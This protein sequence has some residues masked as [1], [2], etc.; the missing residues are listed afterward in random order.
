MK[1][2]KK[3]FLIIS[4][5]ILAGLFLGVVVVHAIFYVPNSE[6]SV[7]VPLAS[8][9]ES[10]QEHLN[11]STPQ[12][13]INKN[14]TA[15][16]YPVS[17]PKQLRIPSIKVDAK[18]QYV[19]ITKNGKMATPN[20]FTDVGWFQYGTTPGETGSA[21]IAGHVDNGLAFPAVFA[22]LGN[23]SVG[24]DVYIDTIGGSTLHFKVINIQNYY[25]E[26]KTGDIFNQ[27]DGKYLKLITCAG[28][29]SILHR[30]HDQ[31]MVMTAEEVQ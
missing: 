10:F 11:L 14:T 4:T 7:S 3:T 23:L 28:T 6:L 26:A 18:V 29:W 2:S 19:G 24:G 21:V 30:T 9:P 8:M 22:D 31:R 1:K 17:Y 5:I 20:N 16:S 12:V 15:Q 25:A 13:L 27:N